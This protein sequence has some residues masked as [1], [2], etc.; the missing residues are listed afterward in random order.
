MAGSLGGEP[1]PCRGF[2]LFAISHPWG[3]S[4]ITGAL[5]R[6]PQGELILC[7]ARTRK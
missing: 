1:W 6:V 5:E 7:G 4:Q 3:K 2:I